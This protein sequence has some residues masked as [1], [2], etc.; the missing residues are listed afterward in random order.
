M[1]HAKGAR[2]K[3]ETQNKNQQNKQ[4]GA[5]SFHTADISCEDHSRAFAREAVS[6]AAKLIPTI[7]ITTEAKR[8][9]CVRAP[10]YVGTGMNRE[11]NKEYGRGNP[12]EADESRR[13]GEELQ[14]REGEESRVKRMRTCGRGQAGWKRE[15]K[16]RRGLSMCVQVHTSDLSNTESIS[17]PQAQPLP[18][19][20][21]EPSLANFAVHHPSRPHSC[22]LCWQATH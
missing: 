15:G 6:S 19:S 22:A 8:P 14:R 10:V 1:P 7:P 18:S 3:L 5:G 2:Q 21:S 11:G 17:T 16:V 12:E 13:D 20:T 4:G 9:T